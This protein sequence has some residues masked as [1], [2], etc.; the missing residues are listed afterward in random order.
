LKHN[1]ESINTDTK[2]EFITAL[3]EKLKACYVFPE[4]AEQ[5][6]AHLQE[7]LQNGVFEDLNSGSLLALALTTPAGSESR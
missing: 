5:I 3:I 6:S 4:L 7:S 1:H 2:I